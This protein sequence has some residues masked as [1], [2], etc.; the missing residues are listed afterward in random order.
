MATVAATRS[1]T[2]VSPLLPVMPQFI[3]HHAAPANLQGAHA[4][5]ATLHLPRL[6]PVPAH[7]DA[8]A[9][10][11]E[12]LYRALAAAQSKIRAA[13]NRAHAA[14]AAAAA[15]AA[16]AHNLAYKSLEVLRARRFAASTSRRLGRR[17]KSFP[18]Y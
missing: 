17:D 3:Q 4:G 14:E 16:A 10:V 11:V 15:S 13:E 12:R 8:T 18:N 5:L 9:D 7:A 1:V 6:T 2:V